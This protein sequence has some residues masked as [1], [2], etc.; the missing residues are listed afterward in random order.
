MVSSGAVCPPSPKN[1]TVADF[2]PQSE[3][4]RALCAALKRHRESPAIDCI[5]V[6]IGGQ[7]SKGERV[8]AVRSP[9]EKARVLGHCAQASRRELRTAIDQA[10]AVQRTWTEMAFAD[11]AAIFLKAADLL[12]GKY[13]YDVAALTMLGQGK[14]CHQ[15]EIDAVCELVDFLR[16]NV[17]FASKIQKIQ[18]LHSSP[19]IWN[20]SEMRGLEGFVFAVA[21]FNFTAISA[22]L[23]AAPALMGCSVVWKPAPTAVLASYLCF[24]V[25]REAGL[26]DGVIQ[27]VPGDPSVI[28]GIAIN[29]PNL[30]G[31]HFTGSTRTFELLWSQIGA[32][33]GKYKNYP[34]IVGETGGK[35]FIFAH[36]SAD[37]KQL[38]AGLIRGAFEYQGQKCSA[39]SRAYISSSLWAACKD[40]FLATVA[41]IK[42]GD[43][44]D[45]SNFVGAVIDERSFNKVCSYIDHAKG[46]SAARI[47]CGGERDDSVGYFIRPTVIE[48]L[49][50]NYQSMRE[51][52]FGPVLSVYIYDDAKEEAAIALCESTSPYA[53][54]GAIYARDR[55][56]IARLSSVL[57]YAAGNLYINDK[58]TGAVVGQQPFGGSRKSGT[59][60]KAGC[61]L[62][63]LR[64]VSMRSF[65]ETLSPVVD[66][67]YPY[68]N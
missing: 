10:V 48:A 38:I 11:R 37:P 36:S 16:F 21:P 23:A 5:P 20:Y 44:N 6:V 26:P 65:K 25:F 63:L 1:E 66:Y 62:N 33:I 31:L 40:E 7:A 27:F 15:A 46:S 18:P 51:E 12:A 9:Q 29:D 47:L 2:L 52:I 56:V 68:M 55:H 30:A 35:D 57:R 41:A 39:A 61:E 43:P 42:M 60:D 22:N 50:P 59:N 53:L 32:N 24:E 45:F 3:E 49:D 13:R 67:S 4:R 14:T 17:Y 64:W 34:R 19:G 58:P 54:T 8:V 28:G